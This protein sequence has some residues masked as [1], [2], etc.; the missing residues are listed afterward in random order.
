VTETLIRARS[1]STK[2]P[3]VIS[4]NGTAIP[5]SAIARE[6]QHHP[7]E[8]ASA[9]WHAAAEALVIRELLLQEA[10]AQGVRASPLTDEALRRETDEEAQI[11][12]LVD[13]EV[14][15]PVPTDEELRRYYAATRSRFRSPELSE[16]R[17]ILIAAR[18]SDAE[19]YAAA[20]A[21]AEALAA[22]L[23]AEPG[24]FEALAQD[25]SACASAGEGGYLGQLTP[26]ETT[27][28]FSAALAKLAEGETTREPIETRYGFHLI[29]LERRIAGKDLPFEAVSAR[30]GE[31]LA[32]R[33]RHMATAQYIARLV[34]R[35]EI[36][37]IEIAG[38]TAHSVN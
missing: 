37:G 30:I 28:E 12:E 17:H 20:R 2:P 16:A 15:V 13:R 34:S 1:P 29:R 31:Y 24:L 23:A 18:A 6:A 27:P 22:E 3:V 5:R 4:V 33:A 32:E 7:A 25:H 9:S 11:R 35:V 21:K 14:I 38:A 8:S 36:V 10:R 26:E 19:A